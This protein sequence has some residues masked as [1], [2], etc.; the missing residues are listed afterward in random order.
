MKGKNPKTCT[1]DTL[2]TNGN[3]SERKGSMVGL[4][5]N[6]DRTRILTVSWSCLIVLQLCL[7]LAQSSPG[8]IPHSTRIRI[9]E[10]CI[11]KGVRI[12][13]VTKRSRYPRIGF[14]CSP[15]SQDSTNT[16][17]Y[18]FLRRRQAMEQTTWSAG[19]CLALNAVAL[20]RLCTEC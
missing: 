18:E 3:S 7:R 10:E 9:T 14:D 15:K 16:N 8:S 11:R 2:F 12:N 6:H 1:Q 19:H 20:L 5:R 4:V 13:R 17:E